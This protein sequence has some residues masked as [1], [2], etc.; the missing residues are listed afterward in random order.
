M[1]AELSYLLAALGMSPFV[2]SNSPQA[3]FTILSPLIGRLPA[4]E[5]LNIGWD[6]LRSVTLVARRE[7]PGR[8][9]SNEHVGNL[10]RC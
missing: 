2:A 6:D 1:L 7:R 10:P 8:L 3:R 5:V 4:M 9:G